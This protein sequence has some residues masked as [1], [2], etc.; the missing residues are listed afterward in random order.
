[1]DDKLKTNL[2]EWIDEKLT[3]LDR[4]LDTEQKFNELKTAIAGQMKELIESDGDKTVL[5]IEKW[6]DDSYSD[7]L[8]VKELSQFPE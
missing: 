2:F 8:I 3:L 1:M 6:F 4:P 7:Q 5:L